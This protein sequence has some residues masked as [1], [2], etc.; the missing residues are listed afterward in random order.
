MSVSDVNKPAEQ[1][2]ADSRESV[3]ASNLPKV[4]CRHS[5]VMNPQ[6]LMTRARLQPHT[7]PFMPTVAIWYS[8]K[9]S[10]ARPG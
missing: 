6:H 1:I 3:L 9:A 8:C 5:G 7:S 4:N 2:Q 10:H